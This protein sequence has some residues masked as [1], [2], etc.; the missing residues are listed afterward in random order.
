MNDKMKLSHILY[1]VKDLDEA[2]KD[3]EKMGFTV[4]YGAKKEKAF[5][6]LIWFEEGPFIE[7]FTIKKSAKILTF[8]LNIFGKKALGKRFAYFID[9]DY[10][11][12]EYSIENTK[13]NLEKENKKL[14]RF[15]VKY[16]TMNGRRTNINGLKLKWKLSIPLD[17]ALPFLMSA[18]TPNPRPEHIVHKNGAKSVSKVVWATSRKNIDLIKQFTNDERIV[19]EEGSGFKKIE[20]DGWDAEVLN[21]KY[22]K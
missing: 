6:A 1:K 3:F 20:F 11:W 19:L 18:Y 2:V 21:K 4:R 5:N 22:Y 16:S 8:L 7:L 15:G 10:G 14:E 12:T 13:V 17:L 9:A